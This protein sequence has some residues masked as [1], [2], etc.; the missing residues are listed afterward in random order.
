M[1]CEDEGLLDSV[2]R[3]LAGCRVRLTASAQVTGTRQIQLEP[4]PAVSS[5]DDQLLVAVTRQLC[6]PKCSARTM[7]FRPKLRRD[8]SGMPSGTAA[9]H[10]TAAGTALES[11]AAVTER[12]VQHTVND[13]SAWLACAGG[14]NRR[15]RGRRSLFQQ[16]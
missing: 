12:E 4:H 1:T 7:N 11:S 8:A 16:R 10:D 14:D 3:P 2:V 5:T 9:H 6:R 15:R 13:G